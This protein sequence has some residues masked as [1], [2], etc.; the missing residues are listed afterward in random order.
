MSDTDVKNIA[1]AGGAVDPNALVQQ[2]LREAYEQT[3]EDLRFYAEKMRDINRSKKAIRRYLSALR[4]FKAEALSAA[5]KRGLNLSSAGK[6]DLAA[7]AQVFADSAHTYEV[8]PLESDLSIPDRVPPERV[9]NI[10]L[11]DNEIEQWETQ[12]ATL[13]DD[14]QLANVDLQNVLQKQQQALQML[15]NISKL[16]H[17]TSLAIIRNIGG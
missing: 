6:N 11:L 9:N 7:L 15:S 17:E 4:E 8:G 10:T 12:L 3:T 16:M 1:A 13:G 5:R 2:V 14:A